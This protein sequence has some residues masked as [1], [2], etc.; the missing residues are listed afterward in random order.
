MIGTTQD[1][2][3]TYASWISVGIA[4]LMGVYIQ[5]SPIINISI[6]AILE[7]TWLYADPVTLSPTAPTPA[8]SLTAPT[9]AVSPPDL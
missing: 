9:P 5:P 1:L 7:P 8:L 2:H 3:L 4:Q 6:Y